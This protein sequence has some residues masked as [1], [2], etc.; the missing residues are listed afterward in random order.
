M[1]QLQIERYFFLAQQ[2]HQNPGPLPGG[3]VS[4]GGLDFSVEEATPPEASSTV[5][6]SVLLRKGKDKQTYK[7]FTVSTDSDIAIN[8]QVFTF[9]RLFSLFTKH[10]QHV[11]AM[12]IWLFVVVVERLEHG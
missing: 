8:L 11:D 4:G 6:F 10:K 2:Q 5:Q 1:I 7:N 9:Q 12:T 3:V